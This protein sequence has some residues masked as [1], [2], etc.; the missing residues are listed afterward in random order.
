MSEPY[1][2]DDLVTLYHGDCLE[3][4]EWWVRAD[5][6]VTDPPYGLGG[7]LSMAA[8]GNYRPHEEFGVQRWDVL[9]IHALGDPS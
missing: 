5:V 3:H 9:P 8:R 1:Y 4:P 6:L 7:N 2:A